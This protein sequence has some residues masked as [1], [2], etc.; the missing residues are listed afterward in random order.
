MGRYI[1]NGGRLLMVLTLICASLLA[2]GAEQPVPTDAPNSEVLG[3]PVWQEQVEILGLNE[4]TTKVLALDRSWVFWREPGEPSKQV[5]VIMRKTTYDAEAQLNEAETVTKWSRQLVCYQ[6]Q[7]T[8]PQIPYSYTFWTHDIAELRQAPPPPGRYYFWAERELELFSSEQGAKFLAVSRNRFVGLMDVSAPNDKMV[9]LRE[10]V[11]IEI[12]DP[13]QPEGLSE[14]ALRGGF[15]GYGAGR[16][17]L[18]PVVPLFHI[19]PFAYPTGP[20]HI[21][22]EAISKENRN[23]VV[24]VSGI[25]SDK[26]YTLVFDG[27]QWHA[28]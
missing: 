2:Q 15:V 6:L 14:I 11:W 5:A 26:V 18:V 16:L 10:F 9:A 19:W 27:E 17:R 20:A 23:L 4:G 24:S 25:K 1:Y 28:E 3:D 8:D 13:P 21:T 22:I 12:K 7:S